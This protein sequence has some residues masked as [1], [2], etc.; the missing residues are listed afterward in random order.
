MGNTNQTNINAIQQ[1]VLHK[2][3]RLSVVVGSALFLWTAFNRLSTQD[4]GHVIFYTLCYATFLFV[5]FSPNDSRAIRSYILIAVISILTLQEYVLFGMSGDGEFFLLSTVALVT[6][7]ISKKAGYICVAA[8]FII[9]IAIAALRISG[10]VDILPLEY[11]DGETLARWTPTFIQAILFGGGWAYLIGTLIEKLSQ[12]LLDREASLQKERESEEKFRLVDEQSMLSVVIIQEGKAVH[13]NKAA[14][15]LYEYTQ[16]EVES[17]GDVTHGGAEE[18]LHPDDREFVLDQ[19]RKKQAGETVGIVPNYAYRI[20]TTTGKTKWIEQFSK[21]IQYKDKSALIVSMIDITEKKKAEEEKAAIEEQF[22]QAQ[23]VEAVGRLAGGV[24]HDINNLLTPI[25]GYGDLLLNDNELSHDNREYVEQIVYASNGARDLIHQ[26]LTFSRKRDIEKKTFNVNDLINDFLSLIE[27]SLKAEITFEFAPGSDLSPISGG[28]SQIEQVIM[29]LL[30]NA[31]DAMPNGGK[32]VL[33]TDETEIPEDTQGAQSSIPPG[34]Y[35]TIRISDSGFGIDES[36]REKIFDPF[37]STKGEKG[38]GLG[39]ATVFGIVEQH[40]GTI[41]VDSEIGKGTTFTV[42]IPAAVGEA[43]QIDASVETLNKEPSPSLNGMETILVVE[44]E[45]QIR[46]LAYA[47]LNQLGYKVLVAADGPEAL[48]MLDTYEG[49]VHLMLTDV[50]MPQM[51][52][53]ELAAKVNQIAP[54][55]KIVFMSG[56]TDDIIPDEGD[57][58]L[59]AGF[60]QK[61]FSLKKLGDLIQKVLQDEILSNGQNN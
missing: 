52:G 43:I 29:N 61:P 45:E 25:L 33:E 37:F 49:T 18:R 39:L 4:Y 48:Q 24:A 51:N 8:S 53:K 28:L 1:E 57:L 38:T 5:V 6:V 7:F 41:L 50:V 46:K 32:I 21:T 58:Q 9:L 19:M 31:Q 42:Y 36:V 26:L 11:R 60:I 22:R 59:G 20:I 55:I 44:D 40:Q 14:M 54:E 56:Y 34:S 10:S 30:M 23:K 12:G 47:L 3:L 17:W 15:E 2:V 16:E 35:V 13:F 27:N